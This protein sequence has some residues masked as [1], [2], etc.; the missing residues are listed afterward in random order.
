MLGNSMRQGPSTWL[1]Q[2]EGS[3]ICQSIIINPCRGRVHPEL[4]NGDRNGSSCSFNNLRCGLSIA[5]R[6]Q[7]AVYYAVHAFMHEPRHDR[8]IQTVGWCSDRYNCWQVLRSCWTTAPIT[9][10][11]RVTEDQYSDLISFVH[12]DVEW[13][14]CRRCA[15]L[16]I[17]CFSF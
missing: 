8:L 5:G 16:M 15:S 6:L 3:S 14:V 9:G 7:H 2:R 4:I 1:E 10:P 12:T 13:I 17:T 11:R